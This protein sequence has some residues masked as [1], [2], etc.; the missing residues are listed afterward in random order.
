MNWGGRVAF[1]AEFA[2]LGPLLEK[3]I[4][5]LRSPSTWVALLDDSMLPAKIEAV[6]CKL[7][8]GSSYWIEAGDAEDVFKCLV[9]TVAEEDAATVA[10]ASGGQNSL[11]V[12]QPAAAAPSDKVCMHCKVKLVVDDNDNCSKGQWL[13]H[14]RKHK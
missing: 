12:A 7:R 8:E 6:L 14:D 11:A 10:P 2:E 3:Y 9:Q 4:G 1:D 13:R 5:K